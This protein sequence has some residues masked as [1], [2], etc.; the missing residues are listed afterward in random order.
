MSGAA[1][2]AWAW[3]D[4]APWLVLAALPG[5][6]A[7][8][9]WLGNVSHATAWPR[10]LIKSLAYLINTALFVVTPAAAIWAVVQLVERAASRP[11]EPLTTGGAA[12]FV[13]CAV[14]TVFGA[15]PWLVRRL[16]LRPSPLLISDT[17]TRF[18]LRPKL[19]DRP[20]RGFY[21]RFVA[22][23]PFNQSLEVVRQVKHVTLPRLTE[24]LAGLRVVHLTDLHMIDR[25]DRRYFEEV[26]ELA[27]A[28]EA[29]LML[30]TGDLIER[31]ECRSWLPTTFGRLRARHGVFYVFGNHDIRI[32]HHRTR[33]ELADLGLVDVG[34][35]RV[36]LTINGVDVLL[37]GN[38]APWIR[39]PCAM[40]DCPRPADG[41][42]LRVLLS[43]SP[44]QLAWARRHDF[45]L[46]LAGHVHGG[47]IQVPPLGPILA[48]SY[49][50]VKYACGLFHEPPTV[51]HVSRGISS[52][53]PLRFFCPPELT[54][55]VLAGPANL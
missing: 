43:H 51:L 16:T 41:P 34:V 37:A 25:I 28:E 14:N 10:K 50:G 26:C 45:D 19:G 1:P 44:D 42:Q 38:A 54:T 4:C 18:D 46:M 11:P 22:T 24:A 39:P 2:E 21:G 55:L 30:L 20:G 35:R 32:D 23:L 5:H 12:Y 47:Q 31:D 9:L 3:L 52:K 7:W 40:D 8:L 27:S 13:L 53:L 33:D 29:D 48:P 36:N 15:I 6:V 17:A 49:Y